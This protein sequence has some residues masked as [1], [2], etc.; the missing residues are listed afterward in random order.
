MKFGTSNLKRQK[1]RDREGSVWVVSE[2]FGIIYNLFITQQL[3]EKR[4]E[5]RKEAL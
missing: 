3:I 4:I 2:K 5:V 1:A